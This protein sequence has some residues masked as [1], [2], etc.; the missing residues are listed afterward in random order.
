MTDRRQ[1][2]SLFL[3]IGVIAVFFLGRLTGASLFDNGW[4]FNHW[5]HLPI[6]YSI[7]WVFLMVLGTVLLWRFHSDLAARLTSRRNALI[8]L[9]VLFVLAFVFQ[10]N[11]F[12]YG[13][14]NLRVAQIGQVDHIIYQW[15]EFGIVAVVSALFHVFSWFGAKANFAAVYAWRVV[16][17][18][19]TL[20]SLGAAAM[21]ARRITADA[22]KRLIAFVLLFFGGQTLLYFGFIGVE[23]II[24][25]VT[26]WFAF[27][28]YGATEERT[29]MSLVWVWL[30]ALLGVLL[31]FTMAFLLPAAVF[32]TGHYLLAKRRLT[33][34]AWLAALAS[35]GLLVYGV[36]SWAGSS[37]A[38]SKLFL[39]PEGKLP[40][41]DYGLYSLRRIGDLLQIFFL[42]VPLAIVAKGTAFA[43]PS[44]MR[45]GGAMAA[46]WLMALGATTVLVILDPINSI[47]MDFPRLVAYLTPCSVML[48]L[49][50]V[51][52]YDRVAA[53]RLWSAL[54]ITAGVLL[55][56]S[57]LPS[58]T[59][60]HH[61]ELFV[62]DYFDKHNVYYYD[63]CVAYRDAYFYR[64]AAMKTDTALSRIYFPGQ[65][66]APATE[67]EDT[68]S[69]AEKELQ[70]ANDWE[71][72]L[73]TRSPEFINLRGCG[74]LIRSGETDEAIR[75]LNA[76]IARQPFWTEPRVLLISTQMQLG[77]Y[78]LAKPHIDT[79]LMI[80]PYGRE[81]HI[82][83]YSYLRN[84][85]K[86]ADALVAVRD[87]LEFFPN[88]PE[89]R[90]DQMLLNFRIGN[91]E[92]AD[93][94]SQ[95]LLTQDSLLAFPYLIRGMI[96]Q[97]QGGLPNALENYRTFVRLAPNE[98]ETPMVQMWID[99]LEVKLN[100]PPPPAP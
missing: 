99:S 25:P 42:A 62:S 52:H 63:G 49:V 30:I 19:A 58:Y 44:L 23:P 82:H 66:D 6:W 17:F 36:Y 47:V 34:I 94:L 83:L 80:E 24:V 95:T 26:L 85:G 84:T 31:H 37:L 13:G 69:A 51:R 7:L 22:V 70:R 77:R 43:N 96:N 79:C 39:F 73:P 29:A 27:F 78:R 9:G 74:D 33:L 28:A 18:A 10:F 60:I 92:L 87:A 5:N 32:V 72:S 20:L 88:D 16:A 2:L 93:S 38:V 68:R 3:L 41:T 59:S 61:S 75:V 81:H 90:T 48:A 100:Q 97:S 86:L 35:Y 65:A 53:P 91:V 76:M 14:G 4:S 1:P 45:N 57:Y 46:A 21:L 55:P 98:A 8:G 89:I 54:L 67:E 11:S 40:F 56:L 71:W 50:A 12:V 64:S 15:H